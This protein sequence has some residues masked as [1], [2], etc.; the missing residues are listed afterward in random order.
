MLHSSHFCYGIIKKKDHSIIFL[1]LE[2]YPE[3]HNYYYHCSQFPLVLIYIPCKTSNTHAPQTFELVRMT[4]VPYFGLELYLLLSVLP[5]CSSS[6]F[7]T[8]YSVISNSNLSAFPF[9]DLDSTNPWLCDLNL[10]SFWFLL[11]SNSP[12]FC[13]NPTYIII[14]LLLYR[15]DICLVLSSFLISSYLLTYPHSD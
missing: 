5:T 10:Q 2:V 6:Y 3:I 11:S 4:V 8:S 12:F 13:S 14:V 7:W 1:Y 9:Q 15:F